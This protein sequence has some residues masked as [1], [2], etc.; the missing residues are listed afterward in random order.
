MAN[1]SEVSNPTAGGNSNGNG[2]SSGNNEGFGFGPGGSTPPILGQTAP[3]VAKRQEPANS[4]L[5]VTG[6]EVYQF[7][8]SEYD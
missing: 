8:G 2:A 6:V 3:G 1:N 4:N 5:R 7:S